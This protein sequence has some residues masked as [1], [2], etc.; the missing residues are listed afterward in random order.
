M[1][2]QH[3]MRFCWTLPYEDQEAA[4]FFR[5]LILSHISAY[6]YWRSALS[7]NAESRIGIKLVQ[8]HPGIPSRAIKTPAE[9]KRFLFDSPAIKQ[10]SPSTPIHVFRPNKA[11]GRISSRI[12]LH[13]APAH[14]SAIN[15]FS[16]EDGL[17][18][19]SPELCFLQ[20]SALL[21]L[22][23]LILAGCELCAKFRYPIDESE[24]LVKATPATTPQS[25]TRFLDSHPSSY[26]IRK[27]RR[28]LKSIIPLA[29]S[30]AEIT[31]ALLL[32]LPCSLGGYGLPKPS[33][34]EEVRLAKSARRLTPK[35]YFCTDLYWRDMKLDVEYDGQLDHSSHADRSNDANRANILDL[36]GITVLR[37][38]R[39]QLFSRKNMDAN[40]AVI[41]KRLGKRIRPKEDFETRQVRLRTQLLHYLLTKRFD[42]ANLYER[43]QRH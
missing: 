13:K 23:N 39:D 41:A 22:P 35:G 33:L 1:F 11:Q 18:V 15:A 28:A 34:N 2:V 21:D 8:G 19:T 20:L 4:I 40:V 26:G 12:C 16:V 9:A 17:G 42:Q 10:L 3:F 32:S 14:H 6:E 37:I 31:L 30:P 7:V 27:A 43:D 25:I 36:M 5:M 29:A 38:T 24:R